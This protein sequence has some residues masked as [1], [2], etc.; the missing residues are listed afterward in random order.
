MKNFFLSLFLF[1]GVLISCG[2]TQDREWG[3][4][5]EEVRDDKSLKAFVRVAREHLETNYEQAVVDF[6]KEKR[7]KS[8]TVYLWSLRKDGSFLFH[9]QSPVLNGHKFEDSETTDKFLTEGFRH[10]GGFIEYDIDNPAKEG[11]DRSRKIAY[12]IPFEREGEEY[13]IASGYYPNYKP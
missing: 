13:L 4:T 12:V 10:G 7:W 5:A 3:I 6:G 2:E 1:S 9:I 11:P 8:E